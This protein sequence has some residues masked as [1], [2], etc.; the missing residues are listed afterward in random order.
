MPSQNV[1]SPITQ[2]QP[3]SATPNK[4][5]FSLGNFPCANRSASVG[6]CASFGD[7]ITPMPPTNPN[8]QSIPKQD[9]FD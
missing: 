2:Y 4:T 1:D 6:A 3:S 9:L 5:Y 7:I 8:C